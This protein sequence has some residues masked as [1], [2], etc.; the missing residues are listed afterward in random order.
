MADGMCVPLQGCWVGD[1]G[2]GGHMVKGSFEVFPSGGRW[3]LLFGKPLLRAFEAIHDYKDDTLKIPLN[4]AWTTLTNK[5]KEKPVVEAASKASASVF[6]GEVNSPLRQVLSS[7][8]DNLDHVDLQAKLELLV[9]TAPMVSLISVEMRRRQSHRAHDKQKHNAQKQLSKLQE[10]WN[11]V[12]TIHDVDVDSAELG[13]LQPK[14]EISS[15]NS[16]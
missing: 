12:W 3:S 5:C 2:L 4:G 1:V 15:D 10:W 9:N 7:I 14:V 16:Q 11:S 6:M 13:N 8:L